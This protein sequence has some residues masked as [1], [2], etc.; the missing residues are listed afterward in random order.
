MSTPQRAIPRQLQ[1]RQ[2][3]SQTSSSLHISSRLC[4]KMLLLGRQ[5]RRI[6]IAVVTVMPART[7][8][9]QTAAAPS[10][11]TS[12]SPHY[13]EFASL[14]K[15]FETY[16]PLIKGKSRRGGKTCVHAHDATTRLCIPRDRGTHEAVPTRAKESTGNLVA[17]VVPY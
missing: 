1:C 17:I 12:P 15:S 8:T 3:L 9:C 10:R 16:L 11:E 5:S 4:A 14:W 13:N 7:G 2:P 6:E